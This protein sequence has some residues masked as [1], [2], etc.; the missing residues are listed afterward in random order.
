M[1]KALRHFLSNRCHVSCHSLSRQVTKFLQ[2]SGLVKLCDAVFMW[3]LYTARCIALHCF[4][5]VKVYR[6][7]TR[8]SA[9]VAAG[10]PDSMLLYFAHHT[11]ARGQGYTD[12]VIG[13]CGLPANNAKRQHSGQLQLCDLCYCT[14]SALQQQSYNPPAG[15]RNPCLHPFCLAVA[16]R[17]THV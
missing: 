4:V 5:T 3:A 13:V 1:G 12:A 11:G 2:C 6:Y 15:A 9:H 10:H 14:A 8:C 7:P 17:I 16:L